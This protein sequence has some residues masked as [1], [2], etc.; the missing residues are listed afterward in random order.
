M[1]TETNHG[2]AQVAAPKQTKTRTPASGAPLTILLGSIEQIEDPELLRK[3]EQ[4]AKRR[5]LGKEG[6]EPDEAPDA[7]KEGDKVVFGAARGE[8][9]KG[10]FLHYTPRGD[11]LA[12]RTLEPRGKRHIWEVGTVFH[13]DAAGTKTSTLKA[14]RR[15]K[16]APKPE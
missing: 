4:T 9:T 6:A 13:W 15:S 5:R 16:A 14:G 1:N 10:V 12:I 11:R 8:K 3:I 7:F 2:G